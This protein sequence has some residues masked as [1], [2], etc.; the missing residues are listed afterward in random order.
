M[1]LIRKFFEKK[2][3][4]YYFFILILLFISLVP[5][6]SYGI[7]HSVLNG[8][9]G[10]FKNI[11]KFFLEL[12]K[13]VPNTLKLFNDHEDFKYKF[14]LKNEIAITNYEN[15][16]DFMLVPRYDLDKSRS[17]ID[18][19]YIKEKKTIHTWTHDVDNINKLSKLDNSQVN[20]KRDH[21]LNR[22]MYRDP[23]LLEDGSVIV[24][25][26]TPLLRIDKCNNVQWVIDKLFHHSIEL[27]D[28]NFIWTG[29]REIPGNYNFLHE[30]YWDDKIAKL[31]L[32]GKLLYEKSVTDIFYENNMEHYITSSYIGFD[33]IHLN[34]VQPVNFS[35]EYWKK[36]DVFLSLRHLSMLVLYRPSTNKVIWYKQGN[37]RYQHD[38][39]VLNDEEISFFD[40]NNKLNADPG[41]LSYVK[42]Y[43]FKNNSIENRFLKLSEKEKIL[44]EA[45]GNHEIIDENTVII[46]ETTGGRII[47]GN[48]DG[49][50][51]W[52]YSSQGYIN[53][54]KYINSEL[55]N[56]VVKNLKNKK[57]SD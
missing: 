18:L 46:E 57:C 35:S 4:L 44:S 21:G 8:A 34:D 13:I 3:K 51:N 42:I 20:L 26:H 6:L 17:L 5:F 12:S 29:T 33:P 9:S 27:S 54:S 24:H 7:G 10:K 28:D 31:D 47:S 36:G 32:D 39:D 22:Y 40:N 38:I 23:L 41:E 37:W 50:V 11:E 52:I 56:K 25:G 1:N 53:L 30:D 19:V 48:K 2:V 45:S 15:S 55:A 16:N 49:S 43:N 14:K